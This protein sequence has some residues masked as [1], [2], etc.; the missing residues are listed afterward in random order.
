M[1]FF[2]FFVFAIHCQIQ[3]PLTFND[4]IPSGNPDSSITSYLQKVQEKD[5]YD[6]AAQVDEENIFENYTDVT[7]L[8][9]QGKLVSSNN[10]SYYN[11]PS[12]ACPTNAEMTNVVGPN[13]QLFF[14]LPKNLKNSNLYYRLKINA[15]TSTYLYSNFEV[16]SYLPGAYQYG[17]TYSSCATI[18]DYWFGSLSDRDVYVK[19][20]CKNTYSNCYFGVT[21][22]YAVSLNPVSGSCAS[23]S[24][25]INRASNTY[26]LSNCGNFDLYADNKPFPL[27]TAPYSTT[28]LSAIVSTTTT[29]TT[30]AA[31]LTTTT[32]TAA[33]AP[34][35]TTAAAP[36]TTAPPI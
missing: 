36:T 10:F 2:L 31:A 7:K 24:F 20:I 27:K 19:V 30:S 11:L 17:S 15:V 1:R 28:T 32:T 12:F 34:A 4:T 5:S 9:V 8:I 6:A 22:E 29:T 33:A 26:C 3:E 21:I 25:S 18:D 23:C 13:A 16:W 14:T 35:T